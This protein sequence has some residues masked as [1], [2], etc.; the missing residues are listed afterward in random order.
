MTGEELP[1]DPRS[2]AAQPKRWRFITLFGGPLMNFIGAFVILVFA[3]GVLAMVPT[4]YRYRI[5]AVK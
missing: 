4:E 1:D 2:F 5:V 3:Y